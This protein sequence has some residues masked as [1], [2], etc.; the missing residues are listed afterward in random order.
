MHFI[1]AGL[2]QLINKNPAL[3]WALGFLVVLYGA[4][5]LAGP[6]APYAPNSA[7]RQQALLPPTPIYWATKAGKP[8]WPYVLPVIRQWNPT[9]WSIEA[10]PVLNNPV[11]LSLGVW[12]DRY[13]LLGLIPCRWHLVGVNPNQQAG[14]HLLGTDANGRD[15]FS[16]LL[17][18]GQISLTIG[19]L[20][21]L[22][23]SPIGLL[24]GGFAGYWGGWA[25]VLLMRATEILMAI[26]TLFLLVSLAALIP[27]QVSS[28]Q[29]FALVVVLLSLIGWAG[30]ARV[31]RGMVL[32]LKEQDFV[33][34]ARALGASSSRIVL[35]HVL[36]QTLSY[37]LVAVVVGVPGYMLAES[38]LS[39]LGLGIQAPDA[40]WGN[41][42]KEAQDISNLVERPWLMAPGLLLFLA[43]WA[44][45]TLGDGLR[46]HWDPKKQ[47]V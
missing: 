5:F 15:V 11:Y 12:G 46:D 21:L 39:F 30:L 27:P 42:L 10:T 31:I 38:G 20:A 40:S 17:W 28:T 32:S 18:G 35:R 34:A 16:R 45:N 13:E 19:F 9:T 41:L 3:A 4:V 47:P 24:V 14:L 22:V 37:L 36:P 8:S 1:G 43:V 26:P 6:L 33:E 7:N 44:F 2:K 25:D 23:A 29:R